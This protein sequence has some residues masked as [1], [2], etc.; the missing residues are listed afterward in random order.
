MLDTTIKFSVSVN[1]SIECPI[2]VRSYAYR[3]FTVVT[4]TRLLTRLT[5]IRGDLI[6][7]WDSGSREA[8]EVPGAGPL[9]VASPLHTLTRLLS[10]RH[11]PP[12]GLL[13]CQKDHA[14]KGRAHPTLSILYSASQVDFV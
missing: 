8:G 4:V 9:P 6:R 12:A 11:S 5:R 3:R 14:H 2:E 13:R 7:A 10:V 1:V